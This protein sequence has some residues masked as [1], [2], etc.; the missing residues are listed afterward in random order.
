[1]TKPIHAILIGAGNRGAQSYAPY[2]L[3]LPDQLKFV[4]VAEPIEIRRKVFA[5]QH[6]IP[7]E[8]QFESWEPLLEKPA[9]GEVALICT[10]DWQHTAPA[11]AAMRAGYHVLLEK[12]MANKMDE[13]RLLLDVSQETQRQLRICHVLRYT[14]HFIKLRELVQSGVLG[15]IVQVDH[16]ENVSFWHMAHSYVRGNWRNESES[17]PMILAKCCHDLDIL[18]WILGQQPTQLA[19][20]G[21][22]IHYKAENAPEGAPQRCLDG[23]PAA[24]TC[25]H[26]APHL[27]LEMAPFWNSIAD[28][29]KG[30][31]RWAS[32]QYAENAPLVRALS[33]VIPT[34]KQ[35]PNYTGWPLTILTQNP[36]PESIEEALKT[37]PY[38]RCVYHCD[39]DV[40]DHQVVMMQFDDQSSVTLT[41]HGH[42]HYEYRSTKIEGTHGRLLAEFGNGGAWIKLDEHRTDWHMEFDTGAELGEGHGGGDFQLVNSFLK[43]VRDGSFEESLTGTREAL[44]SHM[45]AFAAEES[46]LDGKFIEQ[47]WWS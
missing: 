4:A 37:G 43:S 6:Q 12:P 19:S 38:G 18:P 36:T 9:M 44:Q 21:S 10:Q 45:L 32:H 31:T 3:A 1:M 11:V 24:Q 35:I 2:A 27:Y 25:P 47:N 23:C 42:S 40:V 26:Y 33:W 17:S 28:T 22:L 8:M 41:M 30:F 14:P 16:R 20:V 13:C 5:E 39:N 15:Q 7:E 34:L 29:S 46:R